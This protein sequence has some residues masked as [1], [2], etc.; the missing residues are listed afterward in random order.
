MATCPNG[1]QSASEEWCGV[2]GQRMTG[3]VPAPGMGP[4]GH[5][6]P[7]PPPPGAPG[8]GYPGPGP[9]QQPYGAGPAGPQEVCPRCGTPRE[10][11]A[12]YCEECRHGFA[13]PPSPG[14]YTPPPPS[15]AVPHLPPGFQQQAHQPPPA[16]Q[17]F[18]YTNSRPSQMNRSAEPLPPQ[19]GQYPQPPMQPPAAP[20]QGGP[21]GSGY[22]YP[23]PP[24]P[25]FGDGGAWQAP[26]PGP[27]QAPPHGTQGGGAPGGPGA[28]IQGQVLRGET[29][30]RDGAGQGGPNA[31][32][33][34]WSALVTTDREYFAAMM[35]RSGPEA[36][37]L[38]LP[39]YAPEQRL[40][41]TGQQ[42]SIGRRRQ[43]TGES[44]DIDLARSP[45][46]PGVSHQHAVLVRQP[47]G[48]WA[49]MDQDSTNGTTVNGGEEPIRPF[50]PV[51][52]QD[53]DRVHVGAWTTITI[54]R[55]G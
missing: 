36:A 30:P 29:V 20:P 45:E 21:A 2:C 46:D 6:A 41:L 51:P 13:Q 12:A 32:G 15:G 10:P 5:G 17:G 50:L 1:H 18:D 24:G 4:G 19:Q 33:G 7:P 42:M 9:Q 52:L 49:V 11:T 8:Y 39:S 55:D 40:A 23:P 16:P 44:P 14:G 28:P 26:P 43:S 53:G 34:N 37:G 47:E 27:V 48:G 35:Q 31:S 25:S 54:S 38:H 22:G 3:A